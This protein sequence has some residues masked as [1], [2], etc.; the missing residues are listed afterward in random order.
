LK[1]NLEFCVAEECALLAFL[2]ECFHNKSRNY[3]KGV[4]K[5]GQVTIDGKACTDY[6][7]AL[8]PGQVVAVRMGQPPSEK[9]PMPI[10]YED[11]EL[12]VIDKPAGML[13]I[14]TDK[15]RENTAYHIVT[16]YMKSKP[17]PGRIFIVHRLDRETSGVML[18][19]KNEKLKRTLQENWDECAVHR[20]YTALVEGEVLQREGIITSWLKQTRTLLVYSNNHGEGQFAKTEFKTVRS[21]QSC[22]LLDITIHTGRKNQIRVHMCDM[23]HPIVGDKKYGAKTDPLKRLGLH[24][25]LLIIRHPLTEKQLHFESKAVVLEKQFDIS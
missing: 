6:A 16:E 21:A 12:I 23:G 15:E 17:Q 8:S 11:E 20:G 25:S 5:R 1:K 13:P 7:R 24:A 2:L 4:L 3:V 14:A 10:L 18:F 9:L 19:A 22:S